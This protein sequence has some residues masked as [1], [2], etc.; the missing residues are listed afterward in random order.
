MK[1]DNLEIAR[2]LHLKFGNQKSQIG[3]TKVGNGWQA[4]GGTLRAVSSHGSS[5]LRFLISK[6]EVQD[7]S[8]FEIVRFHI[9]VN[10]LSSS[11]ALVSLL[12]LSHRYQG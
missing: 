7:S 2:I 5:N 8:D 11:P 3:Q 10:C 1:S 12:T 4:K 9:F 6:F